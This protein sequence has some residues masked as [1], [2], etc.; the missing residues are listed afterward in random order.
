LTLS[1]IDIVC[2]HFYFFGSPRW[3]LIPF[4]KFFILSLKGDRNG[5]ERQKLQIKEGMGGGR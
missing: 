1:Y 4:E 5:K 3:L 2:Q